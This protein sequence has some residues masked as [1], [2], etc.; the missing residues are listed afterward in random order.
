MHREESNYIIPVYL[1]QR[2]VF[3][4][5]AM[6]QD[7]LSKVTRVTTIDSEGEKDQKKYGA[8]FGLNN[9]LSSLLKIDVSGSRD[10][11]QDKTSEVQRDEERVH[12]PASIFYKLRNILKDENRIETLKED[13]KPKPGDLIEFSADLRKNPIIQTVEAFVGFMNMYMAFIGDPQKKGGQKSQLDETKMIKKQMSEFLEALKTGDT[14]DIV[15]DIIQDMFK[16]VITLE[17]EFLND[18]TMSDLVDGHFNVLGK[19]IRVIPDNKS[20]L[21]LLRKTALS[22]LPKKVMTSM[23]VH[24]SS[25]QETEGF[26][27]PPLTTEIEGP[28]IHVLPIAIYT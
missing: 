16:A 7:G 4:L 1:N 3:D 27:I 14:T 2:V 5:F 17:H 26:E 13:Y 23:L 20:S 18:P 15:S 6:H 8:S 11:S 22:V 28:V 19:I 21:S 25:L 10:K 9:A 24:L 12:T